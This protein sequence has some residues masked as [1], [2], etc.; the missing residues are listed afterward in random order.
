MMLRGAGFE[1]IDL[2]VDT[3]PDDFIE[4]VEEH[5]PH[6]L[7]MS[8]LLTTTMPNMGKT[9]EAFIDADLR[10]AVKIM[11]GGAPVTQ[12]F[13]D[14]MGA[15][16]YGK[17][18]MACVTLAKAADRRGDRRPCLTSRST[19]WPIRS[20]LDRLFRA[21]SPTSWRRPAR[22]PP[23]AARTRIGRPAA[24]RSSAAA[25]SARRERRAEG[26]S[27]AATTSSTIA[28][29]GRPSEPAAD[30][31]RRGRLRGRPARGRG[32]PDDLRLRR[33]PGGGDAD[34]VPALG[35]LPRVRRRGARRRFERLA[36]PDGRGVIPSRRRTGSPAR[37]D[38]PSG[39]R[40]IE[41]RPLR[42]RL[43]ILSVLRR[44]AEADAPAG[45]RSAT[46]ARLA[47]ASR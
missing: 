28:A 45:R 21:C 10:D 13:A 23:T 1:V 14:D 6:L 5:H 25:T 16:G 7:G 9:I 18:A 33:R 40:A 35:S 46:P 22:C 37:P 12:E 3:S 29:P 30:A 38:R 26:E 27:A 11:V 8:A 4:A 31:D 2:G 24:P 17:D 42:R 44:P 32:G 41:F 43:R 47:R 20:R 34:V 15:D 36:D 39:R 19:R